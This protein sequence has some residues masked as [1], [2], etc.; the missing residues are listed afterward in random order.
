MLALESRSLPVVLGGVPMLGTMSNH[1]IINKITKMLY[2]NLCIG[3]HNAL[4]IGISSITIG[5]CIQKNLY[6]NLCILV[7][8]LAIRHL[9]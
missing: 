1:S 2:G 6:F 3:M 7:Y 4:H 8:S 5:V 9:S